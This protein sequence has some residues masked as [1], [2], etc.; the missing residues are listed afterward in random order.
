MR[1]TITKRKKYKKKQKQKIIIVVFIL[2][3]IVSI[4]LGY[5]ITKNVVAPYWNTKKQSTEKTQ[6]NKKTINNN[7][8]SSL[9]SIEIY[10]VEIN[11]YKSLEE[12]KEFIVQ[13]NEN[14]KLGY[15]SKGQEYIV[16]TA[17]TLDRK[18]IDSQEV[19]I[20]EKYPQAISRSIQT[21]KKEIDIDSSEEDVFKNMKDTVKLL[22][23]SYESELAIWIKD[24][25]EIDYDSLKEK[26]DENNK[27]LIESMDKYSERFRSEDIKNKDLTNLYLTLDKSIE[28]RKKLSNEFN[29]KS[30]EDIR[31]T[32]Y[33][34]VESLFNY[35]NYYKI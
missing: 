16:Y 26:I 29:D 18:E 31:K 15:I 17:L 1:L 4:A 24:I 10:S 14:K 21:N 33:D 13:L 7:N 22:N 2:A 20:K 11:R 8:S 6:E 3:P 35:I 25:K 5:I 9:D 19:L 28:S 27:I 23:S 12:A 34:F 32:Y 30:I